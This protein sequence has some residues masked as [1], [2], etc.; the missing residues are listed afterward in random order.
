LIAALAAHDRE[1]SAI[2]ARRMVEQ[3]DYFIKNAEEATWDSP[4]WWYLAG[5]ALEEDGDLDN[6]RILY[7]RA[8]RTQPDPVFLNNYVRLARRTGELEQLA[9]EGLQDV[10]PKIDPDASRLI[11]IIFNGRAPERVP[12][13]VPIP[14]GVVE[15]LGGKDKA[16]E[17]IGQIVQF[18]ALKERGS[19]FPYCQVEIDAIGGLPVTLALGVEGQAMIWWKMQEPKVLAAAAS[20][21]IARLLAQKG[22][23][24]VAKDQGASDQWSSVW[25]GLTG[26]FLAAADIPDT[27]CWTLLPKDVLITECW[28]ARAEVSGTVILQGRGEERRSFHAALEKGN[29]SIVPIVVWK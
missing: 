21:F 6:A 15:S 28:C 4:L 29:S 22:V 2:A 11:V 23:E 10:D 5:V 12:V 25:G 18:G 3:A 16:M 14:V 20:R 9:Q 7:Q 24:K 13:R 26:L 17:A 19:A 8:Y 1:L 27:R